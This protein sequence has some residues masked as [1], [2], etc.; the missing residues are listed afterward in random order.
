MRSRQVAPIIIWNSQHYPILHLNLSQE[1]KE[2]FGL[3][4][5]F[6]VEACNKIQFYSSYLRP[7]HY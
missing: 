2:N 6:R 3:I 1:H 7:V 4:L 5:V